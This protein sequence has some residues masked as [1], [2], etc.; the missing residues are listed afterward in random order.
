MVVTAG[1]LGKPDVYILLK[2]NEIHAMQSFE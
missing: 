2:G 1:A